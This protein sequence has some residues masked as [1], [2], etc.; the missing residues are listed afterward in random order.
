MAYKIGIFGSADREAEEITLKAQKLGELLAKAN[1]VLITGATSGLPYYAAEAAH[2]EDGETWGYSPAVDYKM[3]EQITPSCNSAIY[4]KLFYIPSDYEFLS[5]IEI[6]RKFR[7]VTATAHCDAGI[8]IAGKWG[9]LNEFTCLYDMGKVIGILTGTGGTAD[10]LPNLVNK[11]IKHSKAKV[12][13]SDNPET[14]VQQI[15]EE[16]HSRN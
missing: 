4:T 12:F 8:L 7:N 6:C 13:F 2:K 11:I 3:Q 15:L 1:V 10:E 14:L 16:L 9:T 5:E